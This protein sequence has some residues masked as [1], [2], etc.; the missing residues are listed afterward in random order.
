M[1][2]SSEKLKCLTWAVF[3]H[4]FWT[5]SKKVASPDRGVKAEVF[6]F[7]STFAESKARL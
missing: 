5:T 6:A 2:S 1:E 7:V 4:S 3:C